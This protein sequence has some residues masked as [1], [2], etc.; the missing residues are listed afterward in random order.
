MEE[1]L[2]DCANNLYEDLNEDGLGFNDVYNPASRFIFKG[3]FM[4]DFIVLLS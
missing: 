2:S 4:A 1:K 3:R